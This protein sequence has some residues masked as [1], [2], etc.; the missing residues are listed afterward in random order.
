MPRTGTRGGQKKKLNLSFTRAPTSI[1]ADDSHLSWRLDPKK[2]L[3]DHTINVTEDGDPN[4]ANITGYGET[5]PYHVHKSILSVGPRSSDFFRSK[6]TG[7]AG[8]CGTHRA[9]SNPH[10]R[11]SSATMTSLKLRKSAFDAFPAFLGKFM[12]QFTI[13]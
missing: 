3:S 6:F 7:A 13:T 2:S 12:I 5:K 1:A 4:P 11:S 9:T 10:T 8:R